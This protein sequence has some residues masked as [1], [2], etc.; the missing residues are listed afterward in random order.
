M[1]ENALNPYGP[2]KSAHLKVRGLLAPLEIEW[3]SDQAH[4]RFQRIPSQKLQ[5]FGDPEAIKADLK[6]PSVRLDIPSLEPLFGEHYY[7]LLVGQ[8]AGSHHGLILVLHHNVDQKSSFERFGYAT[9]GSSA[10]MRS[11]SSCSSSDESNDEKQR[12]TVEASDIA[13]QC[14]EALGE[15]RELVIL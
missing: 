11:R 7:F 4:L 12:R 8:G 1:L 10:K 15:Q 5:E 14:L 13:L 3:T 2:A 9:F 6:Y